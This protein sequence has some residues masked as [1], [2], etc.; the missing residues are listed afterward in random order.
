MITYLEISSLVLCLI[1]VLIID[2]G[3]TIIKRL[4]HIH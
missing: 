1:D 3:D 2:K 4:T